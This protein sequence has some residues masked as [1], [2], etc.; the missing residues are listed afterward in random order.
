MSSDRYRELEILKE[1]EEADNIVSVAERA[2][3]DKDAVQGVKSAEPEPFAVG[4]MVHEFPEVFNE[5]LSPPFETFENL[6][7]ERTV[8]HPEVKE[9]TGRIDQWDPVKAEIHEIKTENL[10][11]EAEVQTETYA[12]YLNAEGIQVN[13]QTVHTYDRDEIKEAHPWVTALEPEE[14]VFEEWEQNP[15]EQDK[16][17]TWDSMFEAALEDSAFEP[18]ATFDAPD[19]ASPDAAPDSGPAGPDAGS[20]SGGADGGGSGSGGAD[21]GG[22]GGAGG[23]GGGGGGF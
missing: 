21:G 5:Q 14:S 17:D 16:P 11:E 2:E 15:P 19:P 6:E 3:L 7:P 1:F 20:G 13:E 8:S 10:R 12:D 23:D 18:A 4:K 9:V 22:S